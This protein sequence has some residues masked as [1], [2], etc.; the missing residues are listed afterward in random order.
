MRAR[1][2]KFVFSRI[3]I[4]LF[5]LQPINT[6]TCSWFIKTNI[7]NFCCVFRK[8]VTNSYCSEQIYV[9]SPQDETHRA[10]EYVRNMTKNK[11]EK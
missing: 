1:K 10:M 8:F 5:Q 4:R 3:M 2:S 6:D 7:I 11:R 9:Q